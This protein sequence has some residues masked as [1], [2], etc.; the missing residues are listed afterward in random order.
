MRK[1]NGASAGGTGNAT[2]P[3]VIAWLYAYE[4]PSRR[5]QDQPPTCRANCA[6]RENADVRETS[7]AQKRYLVKKMYNK[8]NGTNGSSV[9]AQD[10]RS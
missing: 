4:I 7:R 8:K 10:M 5:E 1:K 2:L 9:E 3:R 6:Q